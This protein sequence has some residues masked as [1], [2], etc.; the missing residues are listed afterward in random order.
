MASSYQSSALT[1]SPHLSTISPEHLSVSNASTLSPGY[2]NGSGVYV[3]PQST[4]TTGNP[5]HDGHQ[6]QS[7]PVSEMQG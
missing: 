1:V 7:G 5:G 3:S 2:I 6:A 4:G